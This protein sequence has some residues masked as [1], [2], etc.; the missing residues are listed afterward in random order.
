MLLLLQRKTCVSLPE[1]NDAAVIAG[2]AI[3]IS[4]ASRRRHRMAESHRPFRD[5]PDCR[6]R[7]VGVGVRWV[8]VESATGAS[9]RRLLLGIV[10]IAVRGGQPPLHRR[11]RGMNLLLMLLMLLSGVS[12]RWDLSLRLLLSSPDAAIVFTKVCVEFPLLRLVLLL[13]PN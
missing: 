11:R 8:L 12:R 9:G 6:S 3:I 1:G 4:R 2:I 5:A 7:A 13:L 10:A